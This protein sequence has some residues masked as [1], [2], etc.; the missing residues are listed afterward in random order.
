M[1]KKIFIIN[2]SL[3]FSFSFAFQLFLLL[4]IL[5]IISPKIEN[6]NIIGIGDTN[7]EYV[8]F[9][10]NSGGDMIVDAS[11][12]TSEAPECNERRFFG[13]KKNGRFYFKEN[14]KEYPYHSMK[15]TNDMNK[16]NGALCFIKLTTDDENNG[17]EYLFSYSLTNVEIYDFENDYISSKNYLFYYTRCPKS[18]IVIFKSKYI[19]DSKY[20]YI[21]SFIFLFSRETFYSTRNHFNSKEVVTQLSDKSVTT[22]SAEKITN[23]KI[24]SCFETDE[25]RII[26]LLHI[27]NVLVI[28]G[29]SS[30]YEQI[31]N[32][33]LFESISS[34]IEEYLFSKGIHL[35]GEIGVFMYYETIDSTKPIVSIQQYLSGTL[36]STYKSFGSISINI[37]LNSNTFLNDMMKISDNKICIISITSDKNILYLI[38]LHLFDNDSKMM[39]NYYKNEIN[40]DHKVQIYRNFKAFLYNTYICFGFS[41]CNDTNCASHYAGLIIFN[42]PNSTDNNL[43]LIQYLSEANND[44]DDLNINLSNNIIIENNIFGYQILGVKI[45]DI[46]GNINIIYKKNNT[47]ILKDYIIPK[48]EEIK[49]SLLDNNYEKMEFSIEYAPIAIEPDFQNY[50]GKP[51]QTDFINTDSFDEQFYSQKEIVGRS[52][53]YNINIKDDLTITGCEIYHCSLCSSNDP[54]LCVICDN[55]YYYSNE[56]GECIL[57]SKES[58]LITTIFKEVKTTIPIKTSILTTLITTIPIKT[59]KLTT[60]ITTLPVKTTILTTSFTT[61]PIKTTILTTFISTIPIKTTILTTSNTTIPTKKI[62]LTTS[63]STVPLKSNILI[64]SIT[65]ISTKTTILITSISTIP[66]IIHTTIPTTSIKIKNS[67]TILEKSTLM[68]QAI[69]STVITIIETKNTNKAISTFIKSN[70][71]TSH[72]TEEIK[73]SNEII[74]QNKCID[75]SISNEQ[76]KDIQSILRNDIINGE[77]N[78]T[79]TI[80]QTKNIL[81]QVSKIKEQKNS[82]FSF[83]S[84]IELDECEEI[85]RTQRHIK[86]NDDLII[87]KTDIL[88]EKDPSKIIV[89][90]EIY[91]PYNLEMIPLDICDDTTVNI[92][93]PVVLDDETESLYKSL[94]SSGYNLFDLND[95]FYHDVCTTY[96]TED[97]TD[98]VLIDRMNIYYDHAQN[99]YLCQEGCEFVQ[100]N[101]TT[102]KSKCNCNIKN[103][104]STMD[105]KDI[106]FDKALIVD[107][108]LLKSLTNSNFRVLQCYKLIFSLKG[109]MNNIGS[110]LLGAIIFLLFILMIC[111]CIT[112]KRR[113]IEFVQLILRQKINEKKIDKNNKSKKNNDIKNKDKIKTMNVKKAIKNSKN[114]KVL[115]YNKDN[116]NNESKSK[117]KNNNN[118][119]KKKK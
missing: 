32:S 97:G 15:A 75:K 41:Y 114:K 64:T 98:L 77:F 28:Y 36:M 16:N 63:I 91:D 3:S 29:Y 94:N 42:Y 8:H 17:K 11:P 5:K 61:I 26:C 76:A 92:N 109:Q 115:N 30:S 78:N 86:E 58:T 47:I 38:I 18:E 52:L 27:N 112:G 71:S 4:N 59:T 51:D 81:Y 116:K 107:D 117:D 100:Y 68:N 23:Q 113:L 22:T 24:V 103:K 65:T 34:D 110:Y 7:F 12:S 82:E 80:I 13:L 37:D 33:P 20:H 56:I 43:D 102:K 108:F 73:C 55:G 118:K 119:L 74:L 99:V 45:I 101:E 84:S 54:S 48:D 72:G 21:I 49:L 60:L 35:K 87:L 10:L 104:L 88:D 1:S 70:F 57:K 90:Y 111:Y 40:N 14:N 25:Y 67:T 50:I 95:S 62:S 69:K 19:L 6:I 31:I 83:I 89:Q 39:I 2:F 66:K 96:T 79:N 106:K 105:I 44:I 53:Y 93:I 85:I 46:S 9:A